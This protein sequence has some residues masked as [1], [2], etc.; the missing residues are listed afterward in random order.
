M[1][2]REPHAN[3]MVAEQ[4]TRSANEKYPFKQY[5]WPTIRVGPGG[6]H[7]D[8]VPKSQPDA[9]SGPDDELLNGPGISESA[10]P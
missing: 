10:N 9:Q 4:A 1:A 8:S 5:D 6:V 2:S 3:I 7:L